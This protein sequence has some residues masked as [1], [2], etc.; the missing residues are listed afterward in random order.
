MWTGFD[1]GGEPTPYWK[2]PCVSSN[3]GI[4]DF[5]GFPKD[6]YY[7]YKSWWSN[8]TVLHIFPHWNWQGKQG[9][10]IDVRCFSN[11]DEIEFFVN[12]KSLGKKKMP[13]NS[14][15]KWNVEYQPGVIKAK[16]YKDGKVVA[17]KKIE[18]TDEPSGIRM[19]PHCT[20]IKADKKDVCIVN[21]EVVDSE[22]RVVP[23]AA[24]E[25]QFEIEGNGRI[26][27]IG[28]GNPTGR[29]PFRSNKCK[30]FNGLCQVIIQGVDHAG[31]IKIKA[32]SKGLQESDISITSC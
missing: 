11:C 18:T 28:N 24:N 29:V 26:I 27:G 10:L 32:I 19:I 12:D 7:Y 4:M 30:A 9:Q 6:N 25:I 31:T 3:F 2:W 20:K 23:T 5:C 1:Y 17:E 22:E 15:L 14:H 21:I 16:G 8:E 13:Q